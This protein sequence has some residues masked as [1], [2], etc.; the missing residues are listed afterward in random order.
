MDPG[1]GNNRS[2][3]KVHSPEGLL[4]QIGRLKQRE[5]M[6]SSDLKACGKKVNILGS[7][8]KVNFLWVLKVF[9]DLIILVYFICNSCYG[10]LCGKV[11]YLH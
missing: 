1:R 9:L 7:Y 6:P 11:L 8:S 10:L 2:I 3:A 5:R 4:L